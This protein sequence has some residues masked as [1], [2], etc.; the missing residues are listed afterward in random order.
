MQALIARDAIWVAPDQDDG[1]AINAGRLKVIW[2]WTSPSFDVEIFFS[3]DV[4]TR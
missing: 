1:S 2:R 3:L 4:Q